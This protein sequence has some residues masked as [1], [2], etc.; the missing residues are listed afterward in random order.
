MRQ[1]DTLKTSKTIG[2]SNLRIS[3]RKWIN[4]VV[5]TSIHRKE[6]RGTIIFQN[7]LVKSKYL[8]HLSHFFGSKRNQCDS[9]NCIIKLKK[10]R[11]IQKMILKIL[12]I[13]TKIHQMRWRIQL[14]NRQ[15]RND[16]I[17]L[18]QSNSIS[19]NSM[20]ERKLRRWRIIQRYW[21]V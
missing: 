8:L 17:I 4:I 5:R 21:V 20:R 16:G 18:W 12:K 9:S 15:R 3:P 19:R 7:L 10:Q 6:K 13:T 2:F 1:S 11:S 14:S